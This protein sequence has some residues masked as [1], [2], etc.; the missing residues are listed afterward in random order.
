MR[1][2]KSKTASWHVLSVED[3]RIS[4]DGSIWV[5]PRKLLKK[6]EKLS[7]LKQSQTQTLFPD[8]PGITQHVGARVALEAGT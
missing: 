6:S 5:N 3:V 4:E 8:V 7:I 2:Y 1:L